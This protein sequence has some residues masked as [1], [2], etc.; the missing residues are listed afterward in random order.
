MNIF[1]KVDSLC[2]YIRS[3]TVKVNFQVYTA[4]WTK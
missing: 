1:T 2:A 4:V 3:A